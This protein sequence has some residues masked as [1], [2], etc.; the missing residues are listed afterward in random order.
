MRINISDLDVVYMLSLYIIYNLFI[1]AE[2]IHFPSL[3]IEMVSLAQ[4]FLHNFSRCIALVLW[5][6]L[7]LVLN[8]E[9]SHEFRV[10]VITGFSLNKD[11]QKTITKLNLDLQRCDFLMTILKVCV[12][13]SIYS[14]LINDTSHI[15]HLSHACDSSIYFVQCYRNRSMIWK[16]L[17]ICVILLVMQSHSH[18]ISLLKRLLHW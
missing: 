1:K 5:S 16:R 17:L 9:G 14:A 10:F 11:T 4:I 13:F 18:L 8:V 6:I 3:T 7:L 2:K 12:V 15:L